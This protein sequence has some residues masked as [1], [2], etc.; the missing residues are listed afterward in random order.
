[1]TVSA[2]LRFLKVGTSFRTTVIGH[3]AGILSR[4]R[5][6][7]LWRTKPLVLP[8]VTG[9]A[10][11]SL[12]LQL[13]IKAR[14]F[15]IG[16]LAVTGSWLN[17]RHLFAERTM[18]GHARNGLIR[19]GLFKIED[20]PPRS[21]SHRLAVETLL[22]V[23]ILLRVATAA[24]LGTERDLL[25]AESSRDW[26]LKGNGSLPKAAKEVLNREVHGRTCGRL[27]ILDVRRWRKTEEEKE[28][29]E[30]KNRQQASRHQGDSSPPLKRQV[31]PS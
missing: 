13:G 28:E 19:T 31:F 10:S 5:T 15:R 7:C 1:M 4:G 20:L 16:F 24:G 30:K 8:H 3:A 25:L 14:V 12:E 21:R 11:D 26:T 6:L 18:A 29:D 2:K 9:C 22:P 27:E 23:G 17:G